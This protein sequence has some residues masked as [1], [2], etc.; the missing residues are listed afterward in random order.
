LK[1]CVYV[2]AY[3]SERKTN[4]IILIEIIFTFKWNFR[5]E[6]LDVEMTWSLM[7]GVCQ[8]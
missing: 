4:L 1:I 8:N 2:L 3:K 7:E 5:L 6:N